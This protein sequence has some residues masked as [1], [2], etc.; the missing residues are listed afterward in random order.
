MV[1][2]IILLK[3]GKPIKKITDRRGSKG[4]SFMTRNKSIITNTAETTESPDKET[5][6]NQTNPRITSQN[7]V[8][9]DDSIISNDDL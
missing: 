1:D 5:N 7:S 6:V 8:F 3:E 4:V 9:E 2:E